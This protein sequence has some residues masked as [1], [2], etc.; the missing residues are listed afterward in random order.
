MTAQPKVVFGPGLVSMTVSKPDGSTI[1]LLNEAVRI[2]RSDDG[3]Q[4]WYATKEM[5]PLP[6]DW[7]EQVA[8]M[9]AEALVLERAKEQQFLRD[10]EAA[11]KYR[12]EDTPP[13]PYI[14]TGGALMTDAEFGA[15]LYSLEQRAKSG[16]DV[17]S[18]LQQMKQDAIVARDADRLGMV[19][20][21]MK[22]QS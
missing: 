11:S 12:H 1:I 16:E 13:N 10:V 20:Q 21:V 22:A 8:G 14:P 9:I 6:E 7:R 4:T 15:R 3:G 19:E 2:N 18:E 5:P 17:S